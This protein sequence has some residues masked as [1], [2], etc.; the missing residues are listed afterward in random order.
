MTKASAEEALQVVQSNMR[1]FIHGSAATPTRLIDALCTH[2]SRL[3]DVELIHLHTEGNLK[4]LEPQYAPSFKVANLFVGGNM[5]SHLDYERIDYLPCFLSEIPQLFR[6][7]KRP[8][9]VALIQVSAPDEH[10]FCTLGTAVDC[11]RSAVDNAKIVIAQINPQMPRVHGDGFIHMNRFHKYIEVNDPLPEIKYGNASENEKKIGAYIAAL[12]EDGSTIQV[13]I[14]AI[15][16]AVLASLQNHKHLGIH[17]EMW[18][19]GVLELIKSGVVDNSR[20]NVHR[21]STVSTFLMG[22]KQVYDFVHDNPSVIQL[23][24]GYVNDP[25][26]IARNPK[27]VAIN[28]AI[29]ID[30]TGQVCAD[31]IGSTIYSGVGGQ[32][33][34]IRG[35]ALSNGGKPIIALT[36]RTKHN[37]TRIVSR[38]KPGAGVV[39]TRAHVHNIVTE[40]GVVDLYGKTLNERANALIAIA[41]PSDRERL[42]KEWW[43]LTRRPVT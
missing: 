19:D 17:S 34:F 20:K 33:D 6:S 41:H 3:K 15:P 27:V 25:N 29:E 36:S 39:T 8:I 10:G 40:Y 35:A 26:I 5:R 23:D 7:G 42:S 13:G 37:V 24:A 28:S 38:L 11:A 30:L 21:G 2:A 1:I 9:D 18:S 32:M 4:Y 31:S 16:N 12:I 14:G 22:T 43:D